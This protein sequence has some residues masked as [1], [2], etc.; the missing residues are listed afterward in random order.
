MQKVKNHLCRVSSVGKQCYQLELGHWIENLHN[1]NGIRTGITITRQHIST[2]ILRPIE[3]E[4]LQMPNCAYQLRP[5][6][7]CM[8]R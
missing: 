3:T 2:Y 8:R 5:N 4:Q 7:A 1:Y 6:D